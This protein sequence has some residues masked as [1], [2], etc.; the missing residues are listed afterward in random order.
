VGLILVS[1]KILDGYGVEAIAG[2]ITTPNSGSFEKKKNTGSQVGLTKII[3]KDILVFLSKHF[4]RDQI[5]QS[6]RYNH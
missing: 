5:N 2:S 6:H 1:S 3:E 4:Q